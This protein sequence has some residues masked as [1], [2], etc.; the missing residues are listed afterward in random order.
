MHFLLLSDIHARSDSPIC[1]TDDISKAFISKFEFILRYAEKENAI[2]LHA[3]DLFDTPRSLRTLYNIM[4]LLNKYS[5]VGFYGVLGGKS[6]D[7]YLYSTDLTGVTWGLLQEAGKIKRLTDKAVEVREKELTGCKGPSFVNLYG[8]SYGEEVPKAEDPKSFN[9][10][11]IH[12]EI[13]MNKMFRTQERYYAPKFLGDNPD[14]NLIICADI[15]QKFMY[16]APSGRIILNS[17]PL[18]RLEADEASHEPGFFVYDTEMKKVDW[19]N[20]P[21]EP[22]ENVISREHLI[23]KEEMDTML[24]G[25]VKAIKEDSQGMGLSFQDNLSAFIKENEIE[26][27]VRMILSRTMQGDRKDK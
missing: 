23:K 17:G 9:I 19:V 15:H 8:A 1:R 14:Y 21:H 22:A 16:K 18:L 12:K 13:S 7:S 10:L 27:E 4:T 20:V 2:I 11:A 6:H 25:F 5:S 26:E 3:G 24:E